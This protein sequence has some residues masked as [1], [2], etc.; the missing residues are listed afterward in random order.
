MKT[1]QTTLLTISFTAWYLMKQ[2][3]PGFTNYQPQPEYSWALSEIEGK[4]KLTKTKDLWNR[5]AKLKIWK[6]LKIWHFWKS[7]NLKYYEVWKKIWK[8]AKFWKLEKFWKFER[9]WNSD[10][11]YQSCC[12]NP[13]NLNNDKPSSNRMI[14]RKPK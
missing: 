8:P 12:P 10:N 3:K 9:F 7:K 2:V 5:S 14:M 13:K 1:Q 11:L 4:G 6:F